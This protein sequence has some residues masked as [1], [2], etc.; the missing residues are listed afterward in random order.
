MPPVEEEFER[1]VT[2]CQIKKQEGK[3]GIVSTVMLYTMVLFVRGVIVL[4]QLT[5]FTLIQQLIQLLLNLLQ[6]R[7]QFDF[8]N[9]CL[10]D[11]L[12]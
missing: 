5:N 7:F 3:R 4:F 2:E 11:R 6:S 1:I 10:F 9:F 8:D 12:L